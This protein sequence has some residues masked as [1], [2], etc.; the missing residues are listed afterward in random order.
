MA[1]SARP[2]GLNGETQISNNI[3]TAVACS[4]SARRRVVGVE[5]IDTESYLS[6]RGFLLSLRERGLSGV[7]LV[8]S[9]AHEGLV[10]AVREALPG[11]A[12]QR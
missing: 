8:T 2:V 11:A 4:G 3:V 6:W 9:D 1:D 5:C 7:R 10:R 12:W